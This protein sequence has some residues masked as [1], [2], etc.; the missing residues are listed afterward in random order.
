MS[1]GSGRKGLEKEPPPS[2]CCPVNLECLWKKTQ[3]E[4]KK[5]NSHIVLVN[6]SLNIKKDKKKKNV[7]KQ[8]NQDIIIKTNNIKFVFNMTWFMDILKIYLEE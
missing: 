2:P 1:V 4:K 3:M 8:V 6:H 7:K 5:K